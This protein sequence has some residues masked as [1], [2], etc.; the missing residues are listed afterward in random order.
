M[1]KHQ[2]RLE[3]PARGERDQAGVG[4]QVTL[5]LIQ[6]DQ[7]L[8][9]LAADELGREQSRV[10]DQAAGVRAQDAGALAQPGQVTRSPFWLLL[11]PYSD[12][13]PSTREHDAAHP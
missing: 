5:A 8:D 2:E 11:R 6:E 4:P 10:A 9:D 3:R 12:D 1:V 7:V 13:Y